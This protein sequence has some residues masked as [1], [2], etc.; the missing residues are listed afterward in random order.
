MTILGASPNT[1]LRASC[2]HRLIRLY[3]PWL[4]SHTYMPTPHPMQQ[5]QGQRHRTAPPAVATCFEGSIQ[6]HTGQRRAVVQA[7]CYSFT[8]VHTTCVKDVQRSVGQQCSP[9]PNV[10]PLSEDHSCAPHTLRNDKQHHQRF[11]CIL[12]ITV[13]SVTGPVRSVGDAPQAGGIS[14]TRTGHHRTT[15]LGYQFGF[16]ETLNPAS[17]RLFGP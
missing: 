13:A 6:N 10:K 15:L 7:S 8:A 5:M 17:S 2:Q 16:L 1:R 11:H 3:T 12:S 4:S 14:S 9:K